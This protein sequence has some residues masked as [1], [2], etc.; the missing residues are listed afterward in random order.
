ML[1]WSE[2]ELFC[3]RPRSDTTTLPPLT[4][5]NHTVKIFCLSFLSRS[6]IPCLLCPP[7]CATFIRNSLACVPP[8]LICCSSSLY[9]P[10]LPSSLNIP[11]HQYSLSHST[12]SSETLTEYRNERP[13]RVFFYYITNWRLLI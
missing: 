10:K 9:L 2:A 3:H 6:P 4:R 1:M 7:Y 8:P 11:T 5:F 12:Q 13:V